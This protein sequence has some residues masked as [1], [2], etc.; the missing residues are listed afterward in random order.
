VAVPRR[1]TIRSANDEFQLMAS[2]LTNRKQRR[3]QRRFVV[4]GVKPIQVALER[5]WHF[6]SILTPLG[7]ELSR[8][9]R[10]TISRS[11]AA[12][13]VEI[14]SGLFAQLSEKGDPVELVAILGLPDSELQR[15][16]VAAGGL[17]VVC[18]RPG[19]PGN[20]GSIVRSANAFGADGV[21][22]TGHAV[23]I[24]DPQ[25]IRASVGAVLATRCAHEGSPREYVTW[26]RSARPEATVIGTTARRGTRL[27]RVDLARPVALVFGNETDGLSNAWFELC[28]EL[29]TIPIRGVA[30][31]LNLAA[32]A[33]IFLNEARR[34]RVA[35]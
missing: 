19:S 29:A 6:D 27:E 3:R 10:E 30:S 4:Q 31:S 16:A 17:V 22:V 21:V 2:L 20:L 34:Q 32:A 11:R 5:G 33:S 14:D 1:Y 12:R 35:G 7:R 13:H 8:W 28:D 26:L 25:T 15:I 9:A 23:D 18:D 24:Y